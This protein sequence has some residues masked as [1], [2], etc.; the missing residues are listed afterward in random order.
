[1]AKPINIFIIYAREDNEEKKALLDFLAPMVEPYNLNIW[2]DDHIHAGQEWKPHIESR[3][4]VTDI[5]ILLVSVHF[6]NSKFIKQVEFKF[7][8]DRHRANKSIVIPVIVKHCLWD[9][10]LPYDNYT[11][12]LSQL[13]VLP[14]E[15]KPISSW[16]LADEAYMN[17]AKGIRKVI[18]EITVN[19]KKQVAEELNCW[20]LAVDKNTTDAYNEYVR[21]YPAGTFCVE[22]EEALA[23]FAKQEKEQQEENARALEQ[24]KTAAERQILE[25]EFLWQAASDA[26]SLEGY[27][28]YLEK[29]I[30]RRY[31]Q[32][33]QQC[34][35]AIETEEREKVEAEERLQFEL[36]E[37]ELW[38][39]ATSENSCA[40]YETYLQA[41]TLG[42]YKAQ[43]REKIELLEAE[44]YKLKDQQ[45][46]EVA[47]V[48]NSKV[49]FEN[50]LSLFSDGLYKNDAVAALESIEY[51]RRK[52]EVSEEQYPPIEDNVRKRRSRKLYL[53]GGG[54]VLTVFVVIVLL[55]LNPT[56]L[57]SISRNSQDS[58]LLT[59]LK[60][61]ED[62]SAGY[63][64]R[65]GTLSNTIETASFPHTVEGTKQGGQENSY[66]TK[67]NASGSQSKTALRSDEPEV[68][69][70]PESPDNITVEPATSVSSD[71]GTQTSYGGDQPSTTDQ[72]YAKRKVR[73][74]TT[75]QLSPYACNRSLGLKS[76]QGESEA[77]VTF[78]NNS[79]NPITVRWIDYE[80]KIDANHDFRVDPGHFQNAQ[81]FV[82][83]TW[84]VINS[85]RE[86]V[87]IFRANSKS[88][89]VIIED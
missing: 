75:N 40:G 47:S 53:I 15:G 42:T 83:H 66:E 36:K 51:E 9:D 70:Q 12:S 6:L 19:Q 31:L 20:N 76:L 68:Q 17:I 81:T 27:T 89:I 45:Q 1:M 80:G 56:L 64:G 55:R 16:R 18:L 63:T 14:S 79:P 54:V 87:G 10:N 34:I 50:Y 82:T 29:T 33:A 13:Q 23:R 86:C 7:A 24:A 5:F 32:Q 58:N 69:Q 22:A 38:Q 8:L 3:L 52:S 72:S 48:E 35:I 39:K 2:H 43:A 67:S 25:E 11:F 57:A 26:H 49:A 59:P 28:N 65:Y 62:T 85:H 73:N 74:N 78:R 84:L 61:A 4:N 88:C 37:E 21:K 30:L 41:S 77:I 60:I 44:E 46:W 71:R